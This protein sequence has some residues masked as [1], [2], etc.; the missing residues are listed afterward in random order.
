MSQALTLLGERN[1]AYATQER[2][3]EL[4]RA[5]SL[6]TRALI[7]IDGASCRAH[8]GEREEAAHI[9]GQAYAELPAAY[10]N[11]L[12]HTRA[13]AL[14]RSLPGQTHGLDV[15]GSALGGPT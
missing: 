8:D 1:R 15:L 13:L 10:R 5:P 9:A 2:A 11:G 7:A 4:S 3:L 6:M 12:T 14:Y